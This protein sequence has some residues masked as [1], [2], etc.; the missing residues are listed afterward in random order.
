[1]R[2]EYNVFA[3]VADKVAGVRIAV[4]SM[5]DA[6]I[7]ARTYLAG[8]AMTAMLMNQ[9]AL[10]R[11]VAESERSDITAGSLVAECA[12]GYADAVLAELAKPKETPK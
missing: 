6:Q 10:M 2:D 4:E 12:V 8:C 7:D 9:A 5:A 3:D 11:A 1:M